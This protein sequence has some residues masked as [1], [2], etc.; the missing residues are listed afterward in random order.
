MK[1]FGIEDCELT[2]EDF[3]QH[4][5]IEF[6]DAELTDISLK[7][8]RQIDEGAF[9]K[10]EEIDRALC[11][12]ANIGKTHEGVFFIYWSERHPEICR[13]SDLIGNKKPSKADYAEWE[14][15]R[16][17]MPASCYACRLDRSEAFHIIAAFW[18]PGEFLSDLQ[19]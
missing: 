1:A 14:D 2:D 12:W 9:E 15:L 3:E 16:Q 8:L 19:T 17:R 10:F 18:L 5:Q 7:A 11:D 13:L 6:D 4:W